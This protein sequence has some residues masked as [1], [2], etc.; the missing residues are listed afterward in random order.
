MRFAACAVAVALFVTPILAVDA[1][2]ADGSLTINA[3]R[4]RLVYA[5]AIGNQK[6]DLTRRTDD[7]WVVLTDKPLPQGADLK[8]IES[9]FPE[10]I[11]GVVLSIDQNENRQPDHIFVQHPTGMYDAGY[12]EPSDNYRFRGKVTD[13]G[14]IEGHV[15]SRKMTTSTVTFWFDVNFKAVIQ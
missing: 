6:N 13:K 3:S 10:G 12:F 11:N 5:Y 7:I 15:S 14:T 2:Q 4:I 8:A 9:N 1:G